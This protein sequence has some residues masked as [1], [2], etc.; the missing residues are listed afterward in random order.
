[1]RVSLFIK[2]L[3]F[4]RLGKRYVSRK[5]EGV[6]VYL[7]PLIFSLSLSTP[8]DPCVIP[9]NAVSQSD[10]QT[11]YYSQLQVIIIAAP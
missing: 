11:T 5:I 9:G 8:F 6:T 7:L 10:C 3:M 4:N 1:M 2:G